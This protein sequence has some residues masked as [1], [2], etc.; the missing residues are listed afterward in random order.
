MTDDKPKSPAD[1]IRDFLRANSKAEGA[2]DALD[3]LRALEGLATSE[4][5]ARERERE[6]SVAAHSAQQVA[7]TAIKN[8]SIDL[9]GGGGYKVAETEQLIEIARDA[10]AEHGLT[11]LPA[12]DETVLV[13]G[14]TFLRVSFELRHVN[15]YSQRTPTD[16]PIN[17]SGGHQVAQNNKRGTLTSALGYYIRDVLL[18]PRKKDEGE[19]A[20]QRRSG[21]AR[22]APTATPRGI[23]DALRAIAACRDHDACDRAM[24]RVDGYRCDL[25]EG[26]NAPYSR[27]DLDAMQAAIAKRRG[28][29]ETV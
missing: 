19:A 4:T 6:F 23:D 14:G 12:G 24:E 27:A 10:M 18:L 1:T 20:Q 9:R 2:L 8:S 28:E 17:L 13:G 26:K 11:I 22:P 25:D 21:P 5:G 29:L 15:G 3:A 16:W 7:R